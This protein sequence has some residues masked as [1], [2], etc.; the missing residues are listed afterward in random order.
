MQAVEVQAEVGV[1]AVEHERV[2]ALGRDGQPAPPRALR[3]DPK[4]LKNPKLTPNP[5]APLLAA[6]GGAAGVQAVEVQAEVGVQAVEHE[7]V[8]AL[9]RDGQ[10]APPRALRRD[11]KTLK[12][13]KLTP[14]PCAPLLAARGGAAGVQAVEVQA[15]VGVQAVEHERVAALGRDGQ[16]APP[17]ALRRD[18]KP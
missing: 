4:T 5:C 1:Q 15:E 13:P 12:N 6:R 3:R 7:R 11:P 17:R 18:P 9:G 16:P 2:A 8:A 14:N 10:P